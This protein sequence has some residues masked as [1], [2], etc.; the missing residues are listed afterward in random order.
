[1]KTSSSEDQELE[2][3][4]AALRREA[5][6]LSKELAEE[7]LRDARTHAPIRGCSERK[8]GPAKLGIWEFIL[9]VVG[10]PVPAAALAATV[11][12]G[13]GLG[14]GTIDYIAELAAAQTEFE[15]GDIEIFAAL[16]ELLAEV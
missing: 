3:Y 14:Y 16:D 2:K 4:F 12:L 7:I 1:M 11:L 9:S 13:I 10:G 8:S 6:V 15:I 5:P